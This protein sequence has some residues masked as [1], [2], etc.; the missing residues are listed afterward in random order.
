MK[1]TEQSKFIQLLKMIFFFFFTLDL[2]G[3]GE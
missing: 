3:F 2:I 1:A